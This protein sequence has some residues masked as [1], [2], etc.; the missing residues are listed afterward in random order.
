[1]F[2]I[3]DARATRMR[4]LEQEADA[5]DLAA[6]TPAERD[7]RRW[8]DHFVGQAGPA[9]LHLA[10]KLGLTKPLTLEQMTDD[11]L[12]PSIEQRHKN[13]DDEAQAR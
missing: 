6:L 7:E 11:C 5:S 2:T 9:T 4:R 3:A 12:L 8:I 10:T 13:V 1:M